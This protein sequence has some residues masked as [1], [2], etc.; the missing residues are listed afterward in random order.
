MI[1]YVEALTA[2]GK[3]LEE[4]PTGLTFIAPDRL[5]ID[6]PLVKPTDN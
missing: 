5:A 1:E 2:E 6:N 4:L 3:K